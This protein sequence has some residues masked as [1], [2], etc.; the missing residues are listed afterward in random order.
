M[1]H[2]YVH[3]CSYF[4]YSHGSSGIEKSTPLFLWHL[5]VPRD[6]Q[7]G[8]R[9]PQFP[10][11]LGSEINHKTN[12]YGRI[13]FFKKW[14]K[15]GFSIETLYSRENP[16]RKQE[17]E[18]M[19]SKRWQSSAKACNWTYAAASSVLGQGWPVFVRT[20]LLIVPQMQDG[21]PQWCERWFINHSN[22]H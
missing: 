5:N 6:I 18:H 7:F 22:P 16:I 21:T 17:H 3:V 10:K 4:I 14:V 11:T 9:P 12:F 13:I 20:Y 15:F 8:C 19:E 1:G 2:H